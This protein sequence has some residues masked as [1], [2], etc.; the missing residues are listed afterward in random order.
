MSTKTIETGFIVSLPK[1]KVIPTKFVRYNDKQA[2]GI[3]PNTGRDSWIYGNWTIGKDI[4]LTADEA[5]AA[6][7]DA[8]LKRIASLRKQLAKLESMTLRVGK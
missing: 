6:G 8:K 7:E 5:L 3:D 4:F 1:G 2:T